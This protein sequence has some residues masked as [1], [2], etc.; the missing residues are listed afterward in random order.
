MHYNEGIARPRGIFPSLPGGMDLVIKTYFDT[1]RGSLPP[2]LKGKVKGKLLD[3]LALMNLWRNWRTGLEYADERLNAVLFGALDECLVHN[4][5]Y[6]PLD[7]K[8]RGSAPRDGDSERYY[9]TQLDTYALLLS[10]N[11]Y[12][13]ENFCYLV[14][15]YPKTVEAQGQVTFAVYP[16]EMTSDPERARRRFEEAVHSLDE[17]LPQ[18]S[19]RCE[20]CTWHTTLAQRVESSTSEPTSKPPRLKPKTT[21]QARFNW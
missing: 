20:Y 13:V 16:I 1:Y 4:G 2:E 14:Y 10:S 7:Y 9:Q 8:T 15:Y 12:P 21:E 19:A 11:G 18:P 17:P 5:K 3:D 6:V